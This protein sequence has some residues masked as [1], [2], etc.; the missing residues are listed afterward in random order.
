[1][2]KYYSEFGEDRWIEENLKP[3]VGTFCEVGALDGIQSTET[4]IAFRS[5]SKKDLGLLWDV[6]VDFRAAETGEPVT[7][8][9]GVY[10]S[11]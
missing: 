4:L 3:A 5:F 8:K 7:H 9:T 11:F 6:G 2:S 10:G 1:M